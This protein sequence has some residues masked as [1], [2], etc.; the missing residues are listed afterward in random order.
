MVPDFEL[1]EEMGKEIGMWINGLMDYL[2]SSSS[3][4]HNLFRKDVGVGSKDSRSSG[5]EC[6]S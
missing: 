5:T 3:S 2:H 1:A 4:L 6:K